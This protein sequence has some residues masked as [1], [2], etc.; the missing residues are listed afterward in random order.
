MDSLLE[1]VELIC[2]VL[3]LR[4]YEQKSIENQKEL[5]QECSELM[6]QENGVLHFSREGMCNASFSTGSSLLKST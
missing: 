5:K 2:E 4:R 1:I 3:Q 6:T